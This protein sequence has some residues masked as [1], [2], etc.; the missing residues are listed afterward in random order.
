MFAGVIEYSGE[1]V[2]SLGTAMKG[3]VVAKINVLNQAVTVK[4]LENHDYISLTDIARFKDAERT[5]YLILNW[6][7]NRNTIEFLGIWSN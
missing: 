2:I 6:M 5:D 4:R 7:R 1:S 3:N